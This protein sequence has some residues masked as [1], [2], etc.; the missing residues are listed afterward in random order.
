MHSPIKRNVQQQSKHKK[1][2]PGLVASYNIR[3][4][5]GE[6]LSWFCRFIN[7]SLTYFYNLPV[8]SRAPGQTWGLQ[9]LYR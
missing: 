8:Y 7:L 4:G 6:G 5:N 3:P 1:L 9:P 2:K